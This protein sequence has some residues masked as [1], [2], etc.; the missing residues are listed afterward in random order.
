MPLSAATW[1][2][3]EARGATNKSVA[4]RGG[5]AARGAKALMVPRA[6]AIVAVAVGMFFWSGAVTRSNIVDGPERATVPGSTSSLRCG[7]SGPS[8]ERDRSP[9]GSWSCPRSQELARGTTRRALECRVD[10][11]CPGP[12]SECLAHTPN[13]PES[14]RPGASTVRQ[15]CR[16][17]RAYHEVSPY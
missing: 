6:A 14:L 2:A 7:L 4:H 12:H 9:L 8:S 3:Y 10:R 11:S 1:F 16:H 15:E 13:S 17:L 5:T